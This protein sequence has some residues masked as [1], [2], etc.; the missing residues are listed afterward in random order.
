MSVA[1]PGLCSVV[2]VS[3]DSGP[4]VRECVGRVL[5]SSVPVEVVLVDNASTDGER[6]LGFAVG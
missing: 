1:A 4:L 6:R 5:A 2:V 3:A